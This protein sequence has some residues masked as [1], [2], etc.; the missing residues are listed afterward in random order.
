MD[1]KFMPLMGSLGLPIP[2]WGNPNMAITE[3]NI[4]KFYHGLSK[5]RGGAGGQRTHG[6][7]GRSLEDTGRARQRGDLK[8]LVLSHIQLKRGLVT[9]E[10]SQA[11]SQSS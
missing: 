10:D 9:T 11:A 8:A 3:H 7:P 5:L 2:H 6:V 1:I 4:K